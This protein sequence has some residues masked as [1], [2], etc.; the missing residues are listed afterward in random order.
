MPAYWDVKNGALTLNKEDGFSGCTMR[1]Y[2]SYYNDGISIAADG[3]TLYKTEDNFVFDR[4][5]FDV[6]VPDGT[7][8]VTITPLGYEFA[9]IEVERRTAYIAC[10]LD[11]RRCGTL[12]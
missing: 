7:K 2:Y 12:L 11:V 3:F 4:G 1:I 9:N 8:T 10:H 6:N 5:Y